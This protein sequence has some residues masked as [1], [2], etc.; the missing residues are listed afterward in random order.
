MNNPGKPGVELKGQEREEIMKKLLHSMCIGSIALALCAPG[1][2]AK[3]KHKGHRGRSAQHVAAAHGHAKAAVRS[4]GHRTVQHRI[5]H[6]RNAVRSARSHAVVNRRSFHASREHATRQLN[7]SNRRTA[8]HRQ[9]ARTNRRTIRERNNVAMINREHNPRAS[10]T[11]RVVRSGRVHV[12]NNWNGERFSGRHYA[13]FRNY[14]RHRHSRDWYRHHYDRIVFVSGG[15]WYWNSGYWY[16]AWGYAPYAYYSYDG[17]IY[18]G[19]A[20]LTPREIVVN[21]QVQLQRD[22]YYVGAIDGILGPMTRRALAAFQFDHG[23]A[24]TSTIDEP[25]VSALGV[26]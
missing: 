26:A 12:T 15:W 9:I 3:D 7:A 25:T 19:Y 8:H 6:H 20:S 10:R 18:T 5:A 14:E 21:V 22:G 11:R 17:P 2:L 16:P 23:L 13:A 4:R 1:A 24:V